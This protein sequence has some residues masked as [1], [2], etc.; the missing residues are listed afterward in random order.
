MRKA[1]A[2]MVG[3]CV[4]HKC[5]WL[6]A[7]VAY[8]FAAACCAASSGNPTI[9]LEGTEPSVEVILNV[10]GRAVLGLSGTVAYGI[11]LE[12]PSAPIPTRLNCNN[13]GP[14]TLDQWRKATG[15]CQILFQTEQPPGQAVQMVNL[16]ISRQA[17]PDAPLSGGGSPELVAGRLVEVRVHP[18]APLPPTVSGRPSVFAFVAGFFAAVVLGG[19]AFYLLR[20]V[21]FYLHKRR[22]GSLKP[23]TD[24]PSLLRLRLRRAKYPQTDPARV[25]EPP[26]PAIL[27]GYEQLNG[28]LARVANLEAELNGVL[29]RVAKLEAE[30]EAAVRTRGKG[31]A[32]VA[33]YVEALRDTLSSTAQAAEERSNKLAR[34]IEDAQKLE[35]KSLSMLLTAIPGAAL[36]G[37][38]SPGSATKLLDT[39]EE[40]VRKCAQETPSLRAEIDSL[41]APLVAVEQA[42]DRLLEA[43]GPR[44]DS[45]GA[46]LTSA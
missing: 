25:V 27:N 5:P 8:L 29:T 35:P 3:G 24:P 38:E 45:P 9:R 2:Q 46:R 23:W 19:I 39:F 11:R 18:K 44:N 43:A 33:K 21:A 31:F 7:W 10:E 28:I 34:I 37:P 26:P 15:A 42:V 14:I 17:W 30:R 1:A 36:E 22:S 20:G 32:D 13:A 4:A 41:R 12:Q 6:L 40:A 16:R